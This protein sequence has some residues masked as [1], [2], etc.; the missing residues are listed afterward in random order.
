VN[1]WLVER[2]IGET[3][4]A[5]VAGPRIVAAGIQR[6]EGARAGDIWDARLTRKLAAGRGIVRLDREE[7]VLEPLP[8]ALA[9]GGLVRVEVARAAIPERGRPKLARVRA[10]MDA[11]A[12][13]PA[14]VVRAPD[15]AESLIHAGA[16]VD[17]VA[18]TASA[19]ADAGWQELMAEAETGIVGFAGG[20]LTLT[21]APAMTLIDVDG[22]L[23]VADLALAAAQAA[24]GA[25]RRLDIG[26]SIG[27][28]FPTLR[29]AALRQ[30]VAGVF[31]ALLPQPFERTAL[32]G[33]GF[34]QLVRPRRHPSILE[35]MQNAGAESAALGLLRQAERTPGQGERTLVAAPAVIAELERRPELVAQLAQRLGVGIRLTAD[36][37]LGLSA[38]HVTAAQN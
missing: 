5:E 17:E 30:R 31:D 33:F 14:C 29:D 21:A 34:L 9:E 13:V 3:R 6:G 24:V 25:I 7:A 32:N 22:D 23:P 12:A 20:L 10:V 4:A 36:A 27:I 28:D 11:A 19:L 35:L 15:L 8:P 16:R 18:V 38:G 1:H 26:G 2:G 37:A